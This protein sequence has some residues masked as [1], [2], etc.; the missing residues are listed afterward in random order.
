MQGGAEHE[1]LF[2]TY[3][4]TDKKVSFWNMENSESEK[5]SITGNKVSRV[6]S[7]LGIAICAAFLI[8]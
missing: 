7:I 5:M 1:Q 4:L 6:C 2:V 8:I 3:K